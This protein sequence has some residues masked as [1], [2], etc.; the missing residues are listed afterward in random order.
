M[1]LVDS[2]S[3]HNCGWSLFRIDGCFIWIKNVILYRC[4]CEEWTTLW[5]RRHHWRK[6]GFAA[7]ICK[8]QFHAVWKSCLLS[9]NIIIIVR[10]KINKTI[11]FVSWTR[12]VHLVFSIFV[13]TASVDMWSGAAYVF[14]NPVLIQEFGKPYIGWHESAL[15]ILCQTNWFFA[16]NCFRVTLHET[17]D[18]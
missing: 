10:S 11:L 3:C 8:I 5:W 4:S 12:G 1:G 6:V 17:W 13:C 9:C 18:H 15:Y 2:E 14:I 7:F 16:G